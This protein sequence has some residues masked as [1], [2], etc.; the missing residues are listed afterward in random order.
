M[1]KKK[2]NQLYNSITISNKK[3]YFLYSNRRRNTKKI[4]DLKHKFIDQH[5][6]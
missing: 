1:Q 2:K 6:D 3:I 4:I 5:N